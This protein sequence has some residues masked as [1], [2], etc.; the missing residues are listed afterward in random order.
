MSKGTQEGTEPTNESRKRGRAFFLL[1]WGIEIEEKVNLL[2]FLF[3][4]REEASTGGPDQP[5]KKRISRN[6]RYGLGLEAAMQAA[7]KD[8]K[9]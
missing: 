1:L 3:K 5:V 6:H 4:E 8:S 7:S 9:R 2:I